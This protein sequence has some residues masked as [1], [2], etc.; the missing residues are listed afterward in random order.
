MRCSTIVV[1]GLNTDHCISTTTRMAGNYGFNTY[2]A[3]DA[4]ASF[5]KVGQNG[6]TFDSE[7]MHD[8]ALASLN[9][10]FAKVITS[11]NLLLIY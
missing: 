11:K 3:L 4:T 1:I 2:V 6:E 8:T 5:N 7:L 10:E 9:D